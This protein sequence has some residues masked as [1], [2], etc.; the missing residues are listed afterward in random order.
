M[1]GFIYEMR[2]HLTFGN[3][4]FAERFCD[5]ASLLASQ[6]HVLLVLMLRLFPP[7]KWWFMGGLRTAHRHNFCA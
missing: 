3:D 2:N 6:R 7:C 5:G 4:L 1:R